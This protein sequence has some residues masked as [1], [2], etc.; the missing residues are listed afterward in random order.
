MRINR[1][2][3]RDLD[4]YHDKILQLS[5]LVGPPENFSAVRVLGSRLRSVTNA[6]ETYGQAIARF[7][8]SVMTIQWGRHRPPTLERYAKAWAHIKSRAALEVTTCQD[9]SGFTANMES[10]PP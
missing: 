5:L 7:H 9:Q 10:T 3:R 4:Q 6:P 8:V 1:K 2:R